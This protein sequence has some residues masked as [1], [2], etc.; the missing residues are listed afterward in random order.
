MTFLE[1]ADGPPQHHAR[2]HRDVGRAECSD[3]GLSTSRRSE[4]SPRPRRLLASCVVPPAP[5]ALRGAPNER[6]VYLDGMLLPRGV[7]PRSDH[8]CPELMEHVESRLVPL[9]PEH[10]LELK[11][12]HGWREARDEE[13]R[14]EPGA[15]GNL[16]P[17]QGFEGFEAQR[18]EKSL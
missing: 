1:T 14:V 2:A 12:T 5:F 17:V 3:R 11:R 7:A 6:L 16:R 15:D 10:F 4:P 18:Y 9:N 13:R 8:R